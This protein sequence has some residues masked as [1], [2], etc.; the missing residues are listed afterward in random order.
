MD[1]D[2]PTTQLPIEQTIRQTLDRRRAQSTLRNLLVSPAGSVDFSSNDFLSLSTS[3]ALRTAYLKELSNTTCKLGSGGSR[4][5]DGNSAYAE[6]LEKNIAA[7][8]RAPSGLLFNSGFDANAGFFSCMPQPGDVIVHD[9]FIHASVHEGMRL[10]RAAKCVPFLHNSVDDLKRVLEECTE[11]DGLV[12]DGRRNVFV[13]VEAIY[14]MDGDLLPLKAIVEVVE[15]LL[16]RKNGY[17]VVDEAHS[18]G[19]IGPYGRGL[20]CELGL[21]DKV[22]AR[23]HTFGKAL[24]SNGAIVL[25]SPVVRH[26][27]LNYARPL[28]YTTFM[29]YPSLAGIRASYSLLQQGGT[30][31]LALHLK[32]L[33]QATFDMLQDLAAKYNFSD[34]PAALIRVPAECPQSPIFAVISPHPRSLAKYCQD[35]GFVVRA[36]VPPT[37][38]HGHS[39]IRVCLHSGNT[40]DEVRK[41]I[42]RIDEWVRVQTEGGDFT[43][44]I[45]P[46]ALEKARL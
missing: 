9:E 44:D 21:E 17:I 39:R 24:S 1:D 45:L 3:P 38:P 16:P 11:N 34:D 8:H 46:V 23:L 25:C 12:G 14:S 43:G 35:G 30:E 6:D 29:S 40:F 22:F 27:L 7:F 33:I 18:T 41:L 13:A 36:V 15:E 4:L 5:L 19:V 42:D 10:S 20:V 26:Y 31:P 28:I 37:V 2:T 32:W